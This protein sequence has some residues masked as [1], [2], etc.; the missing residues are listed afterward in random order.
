MHHVDYIRNYMLRK[1]NALRIY[2]S[3]LPPPTEMDALRKLQGPEGYKTAA[4]IA[5]FVLQ[6]LGHTPPAMTED[7]TS[8]TVRAARKILPDKK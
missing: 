5:D 1:V 3:T 7:G 4:R 6:E 2:I 8:P